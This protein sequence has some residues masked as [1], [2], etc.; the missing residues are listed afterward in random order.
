[1]KRKRSKT[2]KKTKRSKQLD[3]SQVVLLGVGLV[4]IIMLLD[5][6]K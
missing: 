4:A 3:W 1:M 2:I 6:W 5:N